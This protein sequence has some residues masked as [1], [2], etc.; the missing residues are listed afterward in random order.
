MTE[1][2]R[3]ITWDKIT[4]VV[5]AIVLCALTAAGTLWK[6]GEKQATT[7]TKLV[8]H[9]ATLAD[10][11]ARMRAIEALANTIANDVKWIRRQLEG[12]RD[13]AQRPPD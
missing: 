10:H 11:E 9:S 3:D 4:T 7:D 2:L 8:Q 1:R 5:I 6:A 13:V 12:G